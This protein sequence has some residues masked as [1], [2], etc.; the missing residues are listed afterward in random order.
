MRFLMLEHSENFK[1]FTVNQQTQQRDIFIIQRVKCLI[2][3][4]NVFVSR[5]PYGDGDGADTEKYSALVY[6][7]STINTVPLT[8]GSTVGTNW[9]RC[10]RH[11]CPCRAISSCRGAYHRCCF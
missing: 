10:Q 11:A 9:R 7:V 1:K 8:V 3:D 5:L 6:P 4:A 2:G